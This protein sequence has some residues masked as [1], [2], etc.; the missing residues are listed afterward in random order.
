MK[1]ILAIILA[2]TMLLALCAC[3]AA[4]DESAEETTKTAEETTD[5]AE[6]TTT[7]NEPQPIS[8][9]PNPIVDYDSLEAL[10]ERYGIKLTHPGVMGVTDEYFSAI[11]S[12]D[13]D[14]AQYGF[15]VNGMEYLL[16][17]ASTSEDISG[18]Y[19]GEGTAFSGVEGDSYC[20]LA[21]CKLARWFNI[22]GQYCLC[23]S[24]GG[25]MDEETF[26]SIAEE[27]MDLT[28]PGMSTAEME[29]FYEAYSGEYADSFSQRA[30][31]TAVSNGDSLS[32]QVNWGSSAME[33]TCWTMTAKVYED[34]L[35]SYYD[36]TKTEIVFAEDG[37]ETD[38][39]IYE[40]GSGFFNPSDNAILQ[41]GG[42][43]EEDC[44]EC[45]FVKYE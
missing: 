11:E 28:K 18:V 41:W 23:V 45:I 15:T 2:C 29:A 35:L 19:T 9:V 34:G 4:K 37:S 32:I 26:V 22:D 17:C 1:K 14:I 40:N 13:Y 44:Q 24:D 21:D 27:M 7:E 12:S 16:R 33:N 6:E 20:Y 3:G 31:L 25:Q 42:A 8:G 10:N 30:V 43:E 38:T 36:C 39:I 5:A